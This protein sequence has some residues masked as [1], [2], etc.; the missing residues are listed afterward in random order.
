MERGS[1]YYINSKMNIIRTDMPFSPSDQWRFIRLIDRYE[2]EI[3]LTPMIEGTGENKLKYKNG[4]GKAWLVDYDHG[5][6][7]IQGDRV[8]GIRFELEGGKS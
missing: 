5:S 2:R 8:T 7:R 6:Y 4:R 1:K 3:P